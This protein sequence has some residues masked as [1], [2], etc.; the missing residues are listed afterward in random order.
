M[1]RRRAGTKIQSLAKLAVVVE[2]VDGDLSVLADLDEVAVGITHVAAPFPAVIVEWLG[3]KE[4]SFVAPLFVTGPDVGDTQIKE[5]IYSVQIRRGFK[6]DLWLVGSRAAAGI[7]KDPRIR[8]LD[9]AGIVR[10][11]HFPAKNSDIE[12]LRFAQ[13]AHREEV[14]CEEAFACN[15]RVR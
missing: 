13:V 11:D 15:R 5:A 8:Q 9:V 3:E 6:M 2:P 14:S 7:E 4:R 10:L 12:V 1:T